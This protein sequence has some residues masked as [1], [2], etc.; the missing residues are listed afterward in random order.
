M[1]TPQVEAPSPGDSAAATTV[2]TP[3][4]C[5]QGTRGAP[6]GPQPLSLAPAVQTSGSL[7]QPARPRRWRQ[8]LERPQPPLHQLRESGVREMLSGGRGVGVRREQ[9][10]ERG[11]GAPGAQDAGVQPRRAGPSPIS[12]A[13]QGA[14]RLPGRRDV[15]VAARADRH[16][17]LGETER[18]PPDVRGSEAEVLARLLAVP[19]QGSRVELRPCPTS[20]M[21]LQKNKSFSVRSY[22]GAVYCWISV[23]VSDLK[24]KE[25]KMS[26]SESTD[27]VFQLVVVSLLSQYSAIVKMISANIFRSL[28]SNDNPDF[29]PEND[30]STLEALGL[31][32]SWCMDSS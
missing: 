19:S 2:A 6:R 8:L 16:L 18:L 23:T 29:D 20:K 13:S 26:S 10:V 3:G 22:S 25:M 14:G 12:P 9:L 17:G 31:T 11:D 5:A 21:P 32:Y 30:E 27:R 7:C 4:L 1:G 24:S 15:A 28:P